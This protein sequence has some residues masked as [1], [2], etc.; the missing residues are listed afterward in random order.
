MTIALLPRRAD[1]IGRFAR[2]SSALREATSQRTVSSAPSVN[3]GRWATLPSEYAGPR[4]RPLDRAL[5]AIT[6]PGLSAPID[7]AGCGPVI[8]HLAGAWTGR[9]SFEGSMDGRVWSRLTLAT[10][11]GGPEAAATDRPGL[12]RM[13]P[14]QSVAFVRLRVAHLADGAILAAVA[15]APAMH[16]TAHEALDSAA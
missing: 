16:H 14:D 10:L 5:P 7:C 13:L 15:A 2:F 6:T 12:W 11:D 9:V 8:F 4:A 1:A 3:A